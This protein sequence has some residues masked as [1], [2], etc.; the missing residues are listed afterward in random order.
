MAHDAGDD[1]D[2]SGVDVASRWQLLAPLLTAALRNP[3]QTLGL[4]SVAR[5]KNLY[6]TL[7]R[8]PAETRECIV[9]YYLDLYDA[10]ADDVERSNADGAVELPLRFPQPS[11]RPTV[12]IVVPAH[13]HYHTTL[14]CLHAVL[15]NSAGIDYEVIIAD[16][17][18]TDATIDIE[19][20]VVNARVVRN[21]TNAGFLHTCNRACATA[22]GRWLV[23]LNN[24]TRVAQGWLAG[25]L[26]LGER[27]PD[28]GIVGPRLIYPNGRQQEAGGIVWRD[29][30]AWNY[31]RGG[32]PRRAEYDYVRDVDYVSGACLCVRAEL[33]RRI[34]GF[35]ARYAPA[36]YEDVDLAFSARALGF[37]VLYQPRSVVVHLEGISH[38]KD[39]A[40][41]IKRYQARNRD[42]FAGKWRAVLERAHL[43]P[44]GPL[45]VARERP[46]KV[47]TM[48]VVDHRIPRQDRDA[49]ARSTFQYVKW[50]VERGL[51][52][53]FIGDDFLRHAGYTDSLQ[54]L[55]V[56]V[57]HGAWYRR[58]WQDWLRAHGPDIDYA[59]LHRPQIASK[60]L[61]AI[62]KYSRAKVL[63]FG[64][65]LHF[66]RATR[67][68]ELQ[69]SHRLDAEAA[70]WRAL[71]FGLFESC[72]VIYTASDVET[73]EIRRH[74][75][76]SVVRTIPLY[77]SDGVAKADDDFDSRH[78][79]LFV[80]GFGH[81]PNVDALE[82][83]LREILPLVRRALPDCSLAVAG[84]NVTDGVRRLAGPVASIHE[85]V[86]DAVLED[87]Y[88]RSR[89]AVVP[90]RFGAGIKGKILEAMQ[91]QLPVVTTS[92]GAEGLPDAENYLAIADGADAFARRLTALYRSHPDWLRQREQGRLAFNRCFNKR[93]AAEILGQDI[94]LAV[95]RRT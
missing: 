81:P 1:G 93:R 45:H 90:L 26:E 32:D 94:A 92:I 49:G 18:S 69:G 91:W 33:W 5:L 55:G 22:G 58:N 14:D 56:E 89:L 70:R 86:S 16:D 23:L 48:L 50:F 40:V 82:W 80:G 87:L 3:R 62:R 71:E 27:H 51:R 30:S 76:D 19:R 74:F 25:L 24:D 53:K 61:G 35:D 44:G 17:A 75:P 20:A 88:R 46:S 11:D 34:G 42:V 65:D 63:Y 60:Y 54:Q 31:G 12:S 29:G 78:G 36:Y 95:G 59:Y 9:N 64:H 43:P 39:P 83:F 38:G 13:N 84:S 4:L 21:P 6:V 7:F 2:Q 72:D 77:L 66:L 67:Q 73:R 52:V 47:G 68:A 37:R 85:N 41:G 10:N 8:Q 79:L 15:K 57:L 28:I